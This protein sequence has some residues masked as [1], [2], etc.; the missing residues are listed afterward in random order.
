MKISPSEKLIISMLCDLARPVG[1]REFDFEFISK[2]IGWGH[3]WALEWRYDF[4]NDAPPE[5]PP[6]VREVVDVLDM[7]DAIELAVSEMDDSQKEKV[8]TEVGYG[9]LPRF[10]GFD[11]NNESRHMGIAMFLVEDMDKW[12]R[13]KG[14]DFNSHMPSLGGYRRQ[15]RAFEKLRPS[16]GARTTPFMSPEQV[17]AVVRERVHPDNRVVSGE[18]SWSVRTRS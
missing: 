6:D 10:S 13:F 4:I 7:W 3:E 12:E 9:Q 18:G 5:T 15:W 11:G 2:A 8:K 16:L 14:R 17:I 1:K